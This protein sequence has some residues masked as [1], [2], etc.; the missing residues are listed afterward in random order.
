M[1]HINFKFSE[2]DQLLTMHDLSKTYVHHLND[3][4]IKAV[5]FE[6]PAP[7]LNS[8]FSPDIKPS[9]FIQVYCETCKPKF[10]ITYLDKFDSH[11]GQTKEEPLTEKETHEEVEKYINLKEISSPQIQKE[12]Q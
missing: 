12:M 10:G 4:K 2:G 3:H 8:A 7:W 9:S 1:K 6:S 5:K 11:S